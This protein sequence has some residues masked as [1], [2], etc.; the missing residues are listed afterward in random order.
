M[1]AEKRAVYDRQRSLCRMATLL[2]SR[3][4]HAQLLT[5]RYAPGQAV[6]LAIADRQYRTLMDRARRLATKSLRYVKIAEYSPFD[7]RIAAYRLVIDL[8]LETCREI[9]NNWFM[10][11]ATVD[12]LDACQLAAFASDLTARPAD[13]RGKGRRAWVTSL[14][15]AQQPNLNSVHPD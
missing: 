12:S 1:V 14:G 3:F 13:G 8:P 5:L 4:E 6:P 10:G 9:A 7:A 2:T 15:L 11:E